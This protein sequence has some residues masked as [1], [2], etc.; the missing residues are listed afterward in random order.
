[1]SRQERREK[2]LLQSLLSVLT[3]VWCKFHPVLPQLHVK[4]AGHS[5]KSAGGRL[6]LNTHT[7]LTQRSR[8]GLTMPLC[9]GNE[10]TRNSS[11]NNRLQSSQLAEPLLTNPGLCRCPCIV[12]EPIRKR[13]H[14]N[15]S[16]TFGHSRLSS[17]NH[18][19]LILA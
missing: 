19:G 12:W 7:P 13:A 8:S 6:H 5:A 17:L 15:L 18:C 2:F 14:P 1:M 3:P 9:S 16:G 4:D 10:L 11:G